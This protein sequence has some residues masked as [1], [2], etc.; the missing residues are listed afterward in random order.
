MGLR[1]ATASFTVDRVL[2]IFGTHGRSPVALSQHLHKHESP[3][4]PS[5]VYKIGETMQGEG[6]DVV[7]VEQLDLGRDP[8]TLMSRSPHVAS[9]PVPCGATLDM[10]DP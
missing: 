8:T 7:L 9:S 1:I 6:L 10:V 5:T 3:N 2:A 4:P